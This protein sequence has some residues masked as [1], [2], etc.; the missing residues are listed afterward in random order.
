MKDLGHVQLPTNS[1]EHSR[2]APTG[3]RLVLWALL[4]FACTFASATMMDD[5]AR[6][7]L[8]WSG[9][10]SG[11]YLVSAVLA[12]FFAALVRRRSRGPAG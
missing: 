5:I 10:K 4:I 1:Q 8:G 7:V 9:S 3:K 12:V 11:N 2:A 6:L